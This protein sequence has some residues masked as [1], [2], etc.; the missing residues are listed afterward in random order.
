MKIKSPQK[1]KLKTQFSHSLFN[2]G[3]ETEKGKKAHPLLLIKNRKQPCA[4]AQ[5]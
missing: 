3:K 4:A 1:I 2:P 5:K